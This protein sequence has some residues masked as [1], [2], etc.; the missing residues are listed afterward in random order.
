MTDAKLLWV[1]FRLVLYRRVDG[2]VLKNF[3]FIRGHSTFPLNPLKIPS[4][5]VCKENEA[6]TDGFFGFF[7][8]IVGLKCCLWTLTLR[9]GALEPLPPTAETGS[10]KGR[11]V[12]VGVERGRL[13]LPSHPAS[14]SSLLFFTLER[15]DLETDGC[16]M[17]TFVAGVA[18]EAAAYAGGLG[19]MML[20]GGRD[21]VVVGV[22]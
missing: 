20:Q 17:G 3:S 18:A 1:P 11:V 13:F 6:L 8:E 19:Y 21:A 4:F 5:L 10:T 7:R 16:T 15:F 14:F 2:N 9:P 12:E 22:N